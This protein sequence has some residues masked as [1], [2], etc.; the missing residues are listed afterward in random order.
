MTMKSARRKSASGHV[1]GS[2]GLPITGKGHLCRPVLVEK[3][4]GHCGLRL[5][6]VR[7]LCPSGQG[8]RRFVCGVCGRAA[9][10]PTD[11]CRPVRI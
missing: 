11:V 2:C 3:R 10:S 8:E 9:S 1:C 4:C 7:H 5:E 6:N